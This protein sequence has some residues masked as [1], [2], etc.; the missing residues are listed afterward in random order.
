MKAC[1]HHV[2]YGQIEYSENVWSGKRELSISGQKLPMKKKN[3]FTV[4]TENGPL[5]C[6]VKG[7]FLTGATLFIDRDIIPL[8]GPCKWYEL[9]CS[10]SIILF[11]MVWGNVPQL[12]AIFP[13]IGGAIGGGICGFLGSINLILMRQT[14]NVGAKLLIF[15][16]MFLGTVL[17]CFF[18]AL[19]FLFFAQLGS[20]K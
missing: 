7:N 10:L 17:L 19:F 8:L 14:K 9:L 11:V 5:D 12:C 20:V 2:G 1:V 4:N 16:G 6:R 18:I 13:I 15:L 3:T